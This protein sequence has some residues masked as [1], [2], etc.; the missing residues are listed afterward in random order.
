MTPKAINSAARPLKCKLC[1]RRFKYAA[2]MKDHIQTDHKPELY[3]FLLK[4]RA[5]QHQLAEL[6]RQ[7]TKTAVQNPVGNPVRTAVTPPVRVSVIQKVPEI[8][9]ALQKMLDQQCA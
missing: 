6:L 8:P 9:F 5:Q 4:K 2:C 1:S 7:L 3:R